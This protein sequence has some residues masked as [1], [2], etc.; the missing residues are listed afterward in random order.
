MNEETQA[1]MFSS[2]SEE[3]A[4]PRALLEVVRQEYPIALDVC[5][6]PENTACP[7]YFTKA[8]NALRLPWTGCCWMN[9]PYG[10]GIGAWIAKAAQSAREGATVVCL[11]PA[12]T[13]TKWWHA[14][15]QPI[16]EEHGTK[17]V[18]FLAGRLHFNEAETGAP[19]PS[20]IV[21]FAP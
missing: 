21:V 6:T 7:A 15:C 3:W 5:A 11:L 9:P 4:T 20:V 13:D 8:D 10:R 14:H 12:R 1:V 19:F 2:T 16:L 18:T 17:R